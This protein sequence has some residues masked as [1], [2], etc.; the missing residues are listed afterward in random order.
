MR[1][2]RFQQELSGELGEYWVKEAKRKIDEAEDRIVNGEIEFRFGVP[3]WANVNRI[4]PEDYREY[5]AEGCFAGLLDEERTTEE[6]R[7]ANEKWLAEYREAMKDYEPSEEELF[8]MRAA[9]GEGA[10]VV[11]V[12]TGKEIKL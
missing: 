6:A 9:F 11:N 2:T 1:K 4:V 10:T 5:I 12:F 3:Y 7:I 8:E